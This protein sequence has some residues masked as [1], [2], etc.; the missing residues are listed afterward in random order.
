MHKC[1]T[2]TSGDLRATRAVV[3]LRVEWAGCVSGMG[4][5]GGIAR[6]VADLGDH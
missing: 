3:R 1:S 4:E 5:R 6:D 2:D